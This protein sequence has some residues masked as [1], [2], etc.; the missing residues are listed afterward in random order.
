MDKENLD[1]LDILT[2]LSFVIGLQSYQIAIK[3]LKENEEQTDDI[4]K[5]LYEVNEHLNHQDMI[6]KNQ[7]EIL[8]ELKE[9]IRVESK[10]I[11]K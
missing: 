2:I 9:V 1:I 10:R 11:D 8:Y 6:L 4:R 5:I 3:N 7:D